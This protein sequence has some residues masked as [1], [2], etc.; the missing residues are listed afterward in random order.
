MTPKVP[1]PKPRIIGITA[2]DYPYK[3]SLLTVGPHVK[4]EKPSQ[5]PRTPEDVTAPP[6]GS[7]DENSELSSLLSDADL[8]GLESPPPRTKRTRTTKVRVPVVGA[9][10]QEGQSGH[11]PDKVAAI[12]HGSMEPSRISHTTWKSSGR[13]LEGQNMNGKHN[14]GKRRSQEIEEEGPFDDFTALHKRPQTYYGGLGN[15]HGFGALQRKKISG[16]NSFTAVTKNEKNGFRKPNTKDI[17]A[18][19]LWYLKVLIIKAYLL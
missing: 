13:N 10:A 15:I 1:H 8:S 5:R 14:G 17:D 16:R 9:T 18:I 11:G 4:I 6:I 7:S 19:R 2:R 12:S 3:G